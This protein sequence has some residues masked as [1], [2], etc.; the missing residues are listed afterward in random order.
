[1]ANG[2]K[3]QAEDF[4]SAIKKAR[5]LFKDRPGSEFSLRDVQVTRAAPSNAE[6]KNLLNW[7]GFNRRE[8]FADSTDGLMASI[9]YDEMF[10]A[11][12]SQAAQPR[13]EGLDGIKSK[14][15]KEAARLALGQDLISDSQEDWNVKVPASVLHQIDKQNQ[16]L[17]SQAQRLKLIADE[18]TTACRY[19]DSQLTDEEVEGL[20]QTL[21]EAYDNDPNIP[22][23]TE[24]LNGGDL[25]WAIDHL[26]ARNMIVRGT[27]E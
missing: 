25:K 21:Q 2:A 12:Q 18:L 19:R 11:L 6:A 22:T 20:K 5:D 9:C 24:T 26:R 10:T 15:I 3:V 13:P 27:G 23:G 7:K 1:M 4:K 16:R 17:R 14:I 8:C